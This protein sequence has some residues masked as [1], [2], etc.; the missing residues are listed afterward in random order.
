MNHNSKPTGDARGRRD[1]A[2]RLADADDRLGGDGRQD[3]REN[4]RLAS[5][6][7]ELARLR[8]TVDDLAADTLDLNNQLDRL[9]SICERLVGGALADAA[10]RRVSGLK[11]AVSVAGLTARRVA[12][13]VVGA[14]RS[15]TGN[16]RPA[17]RRPPAVELKIAERPVTRSPD[18][19]VIARTAADPETVGRRHAIG[20][21]TD[22]RFD[23]VVWNR[24]RSRAVLYEQG[25]DPRAVVAG[26]RAALTAELSAELVADV[27]DGGA[28]LHPTLIERC[29]W[30]AASEGI[31]LV[32]GPSG[33]EARWRVMPRSAWAEHGG[34][35]TG[36][37]L[38]KR[39]DTGGW[40]PWAE[41]GTPAVA[42]GA[43]SGYLCTGDG[44]VVEH[45]VAPLAGVVQPVASADGR[46]PV[47]V[48]TSRRGA[49]AT[50]WLVG[51][52]GGRFRSTVVVTDAG[53]RDA[54]VRALTELTE[55]VYP[56]RGFLAP[57]V[58][59]SVVADVA[60]AHAAS[61]VLR[62]DADIDID[63]GTDAPRVIDLPFEPSGVD[64]SA[65]VVIALGAS[66]ADAARSH[67]IDIVEL[68]PGPAMADSMPRP[69][70]LAGVRAAYGVPE[71]ARLVLAAVALEPDQRPEDVASVA[72]RLADRA[73]IHILLVGQGTLAGTVSDLAGYLG[74]GNFS[75]APQGH[76]LTDLIAA[77]D[78]LLSTAEID[79]WPVATATA[80]ALGRSVVATDVD[81]VR[82][83]CAAAGFDRCRLCRPGDV[84][85]LA[86]AVGD[87]VDSDRAPRMT[88]K[89]WTAAGARATVA[90]RTVLELL[91]RRA[92]A[93]EKAN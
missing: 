24:E 86:Q 23:L 67:E 50:A 3:E 13:R 56:L 84:D 4:T 85:A 92:G 71:G 72:R 15:L 27:G 90:A 53:E 47:L 7:A 66:I 28:L 22:P 60:R 69:E 80:L 57:E 75:F 29:R 36:M 65:D 91:D 78:C 43:G 35:E 32:G 42:S 33:S 74:L 14:A 63:V 58:W 19:V 10:D 30:A 51:A 70:E 59:P 21:Q 68:V 76:P 11:H 26:S 55:W 12:G 79:P 16:R 62:V 2:G 41:V 49:G 31:P 1:L 93:V 54:S 48:V 20:N 87:A 64:G 18:L 9:V 88:R 82:E 77:C 34:A 89:A 61:V 17:V 40:G 5:I 83:L 6:E 45:S 38:V 52:L 46:R 44:G 8:K 37:R 25:R 39:V 73:E 81:G